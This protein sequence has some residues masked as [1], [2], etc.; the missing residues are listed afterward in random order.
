M[1][2][3]LRYSSYIVDVYSSHRQKEGVQG[4]TSFADIGNRD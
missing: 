1:N 3:V 2:N 4:E